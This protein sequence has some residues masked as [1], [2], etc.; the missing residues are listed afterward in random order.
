MIMNI[1]IAIRKVI[2]TII[3]NFFIKGVRI[4]IALL[5]NIKIRI[6]YSNIY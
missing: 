2:I 5:G 6:I 3:I 1:I 4:I